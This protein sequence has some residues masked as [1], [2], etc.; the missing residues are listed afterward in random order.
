MDEMNRVLRYYK[1]LITKYR[2]RTFCNKK[3]KTQAMF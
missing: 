3:K 2:K 1:R